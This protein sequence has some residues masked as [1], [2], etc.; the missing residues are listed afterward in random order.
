MIAL[1]IISILWI[2]LN[3]IRDYGFINNRSG[4]WHSAD[5]AQRVMLSMYV[6]YIIFGSL[7]YAFVFLIGYWILFD[8]I[9]NFFNKK[10]LLY[11]GQTAFIDV[12]FRMIA[13]VLNKKA[14]TIMIITKGVVL[15]II[16]FFTI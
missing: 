13:M 10:K 2:A 4:I 14:S 5:A 8:L 16:L 3:A 7:G 15:A 1:T 6:S 11:V 12:A 9:L